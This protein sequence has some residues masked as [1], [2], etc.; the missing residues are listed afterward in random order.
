M[1]LGHHLAV[2]SFY[3]LAAI[4]LAIGLF[5]PE[6]YD[7]TGQDQSYHSPR[8][9]G[10]LITIPVVALVFS[11]SM[12]W[13]PKADPSSPRAQFNV[14]G[15]LIAITLIAISLAAIPVLSMV[16][17]VLVCVGGYAY[18]AWI[19][20]DPKRRLAALTFLGCALA[21]FAWVFKY[22]HPWDTNPL[23]A[24]TLPALLPAMF[25]ASMTDMNMHQSPQLPAYLTGIY[26]LAALT[27]ARFGR[28]W[29]VAV[30]TW[31]LV[32]SIF[33]SLTLHA[34]IRA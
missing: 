16:P 17:S 22:D 19:A 30:N 34:M 12:F 26:Y 25:T 10:L 7:W 24:G 3:S 21:P 13:W 8:T 32:A 11:V 15:M 9:T 18:V 20:L 1:S 6:I 27:L 14:R 5:V 4:A 29:S 33:G 28:R 31:T 2:W 23:V